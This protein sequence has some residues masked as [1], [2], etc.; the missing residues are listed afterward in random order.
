[1]QDKNHIHAVNNLTQTPQRNTTAPSS[2]LKLV[3]IFG[4]QYTES[5]TP[6]DFCIFRGHG[7]EETGQPRFLWPGACTSGSSTS[8]PQGA[9]PFLEEVSGSDKKQGGVRSNPTQ[10]KLLETPC[11]GVLPTNKLVKSR[12][13]NPNHQLRRVGT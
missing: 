1:M 10:P 7:V 8:W 11:I 13:T 3:R 5:P 12:N 9:A 2:L 4:D 6:G